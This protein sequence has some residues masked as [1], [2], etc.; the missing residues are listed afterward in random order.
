M[1]SKLLILVLFALSQC[2]H[3]KSTVLFSL[4]FT[5]EMADKAQN[6]RLLLML[7][8][9]DKSEPR[10][11]ISDGLKTQLVFGIDVDDMKPGQEIIISENAFGFPIR[12]VSG[13][14][15]RKSVV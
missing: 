3:K 15:D 9:N 7:S 4:S 1:K 10:M 2:T 13:I 11:Q 5:K 6:G 12:S 8:N 14:P